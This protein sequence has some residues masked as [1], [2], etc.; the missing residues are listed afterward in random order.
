MTNFCFGRSFKKEQP[1]LKE[2]KEAAMRIRQ[3]QNTEEGE[4]I[5]TMTKLI[6]CVDLERPFFF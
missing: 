1:D 6:L 3:R 2:V 5:P 4:K